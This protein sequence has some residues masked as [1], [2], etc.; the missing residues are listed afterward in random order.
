LQDIPDLVDGLRRSIN[1][2]STFVTSIPEEK[3]TRRRGA[4]FWSVAEH[5]VHLAQVQPML[6]GRLQRFLSEDR[7]EFAPY[8]PGDAGQ[9]DK[10][11][12][13]V[14]GAALSEFE[15]YRLKQLALLDEV[16]E[17]AWQKTA[18]HPEYDFYTLHILTRH[19]LLHDHW[20][21]Y[22]MEQLWLTRDEFLKQ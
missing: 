7:P 6:L 17:A 1:I 2:L 10:P 3:L 8:I 16:D 4:G 18:I 11:P 13:M 5:T 19:I 21:M 14:T 15:H 20:H 9:D 12:Q 22:R